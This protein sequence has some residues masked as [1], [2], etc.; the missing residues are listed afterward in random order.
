MP[1]A[2][3]PSEPYAGTGGYTRLG[4]N[5]KWS[6]VGGTHVVGAM[7]DVRIYGRALSAAEVETLAR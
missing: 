1:L 3:R 6:D 7:R 5:P 4:W 2:H